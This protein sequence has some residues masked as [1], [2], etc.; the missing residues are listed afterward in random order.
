M[1]TVILWKLHTDK[2]DPYYG[3]KGMEQCIKE[4]ISLDSTSDLTT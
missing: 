4:G 1:S 3:I 2:G